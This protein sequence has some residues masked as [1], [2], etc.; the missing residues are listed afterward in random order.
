ML[1]GEKMIGI[2]Y[3]TLLMIMFILL[4]RQAPYI[5]YS[6]FMLFIFILA[7]IEFFLGYLD[8][9]KLF[10]WHRYCPHCEG[11]WNS[12]KYRKEK[13]VNDKGKTGQKNDK[14]NK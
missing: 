11:E 8:A 7:I 14:K 4:T 13:I 9:S 6:P 2:R 10:K 12:S 1:L 3:L 5:D